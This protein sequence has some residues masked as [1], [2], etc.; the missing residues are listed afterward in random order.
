LSPE[1][2]AMPV[3]ATVHRLASVPS[4]NDV[5]RDLARQGAAHGTAVLAGEQTLGRG[6]KGRTWHSP[7][8]LGLYASFVLRG[9]GGGAVPTPHL[10]PLAAGLAASD[11]VFEAAA[12]ATALKWPNDLL[13]EGR[14]LG[15]VLCE[16][17]SGGPAGDFVIAGIGL[18]IGHESADFPAAIRPASTSVRLAAGR[19]VPVEAV[20][21]AL[22]RALER[23]YNVLARGDRA[24]VVGAFEARRAFPRGA[25]LKIETADGT[26]EA[27]YRGLDADGRLVVAR[28][29]AGTVA[30]DAVLKLERAS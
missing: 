16:G 18:D 8:G 13:F 1:A 4:T 21:A 20:F 7:A 30:L 15:G 9:P 3:G 27:A 14:K 28:A 24:A 10:L 26:F 12:V 29:G 6:T 5:A 11:A 19:D 17:V 2:E 25:A 23:W 22:C